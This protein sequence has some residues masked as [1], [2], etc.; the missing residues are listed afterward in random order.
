M[1]LWSEYSQANSQ[2]YGYSRFCD[3]YRAWAKTLDVVMRQSHKAGE[4]MFV[5]YAGMTMG[6]VDRKPA[7]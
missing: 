1:L 2:G 5:D 6:V 3:L 7:K 4:K